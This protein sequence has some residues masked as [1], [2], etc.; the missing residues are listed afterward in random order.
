MMHFDVS[1][2]PSRSAVVSA[3][4]CDASG[5]EQSHQNQKSLGAVGGQRRVGSPVTVS[6]PKENGEQFP[7]KTEQR[8]SNSQESNS[9]K[10]G[11][12]ECCETA[13][14]KSGVAV[15]LFWGEGEER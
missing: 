5:G 7:G 6:G 1:L 13:A 8:V 11:E 4:T 9:Q 3:L 15:S 2:L 14:E 12:Q 10:G